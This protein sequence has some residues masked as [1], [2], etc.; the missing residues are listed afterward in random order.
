MI[1]RGSRMIV[2]HTMSKD[3]WVKGALWTN[4]T[5]GENADYHKDMNSEQ[6]EN[7][8][9]KQLF[10]KLKELSIDKGR[11]PVL[12]MDNAPYHTRKRVLLPTKSAT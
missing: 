3:G 4:V 5:K 7:Y 11:K 12:I 9:D 1:P 2:L 6:F 8:L 10:P